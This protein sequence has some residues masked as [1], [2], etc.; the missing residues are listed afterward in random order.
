MSRWHKTPA[1]DG[2]AGVVD[3][4]DIRPG[5]VADAIALASLAADHI[6][7]FSCIKL[8]ALLRRQPL[9]QK[10]QAAFFPTVH[11]LELARER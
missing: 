3:F 9:S 8:C 7:M 11:Y 2:P 6:E 10:R 4:M 5:T 1:H